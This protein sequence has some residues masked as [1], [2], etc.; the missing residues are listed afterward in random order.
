MKN[1]QT[2][3]SIAAALVLIFF[4]AGSVRADDP[5]LSKIFKDR[6]IEGTIVISSLD[7]KIEYVHN[8]YRSEIRFIPASTF[9]IPNTLI[10]LEEG[11]IKNEKEIIKWDGKNKGFDAWNTDQTLETAFS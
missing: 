7:G 6:D 4:A 10:A 9:K 8:N 5:D 3:L 1:T 2:L 11:V